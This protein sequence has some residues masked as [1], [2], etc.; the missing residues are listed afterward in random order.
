MCRF[1]TLGFQGIHLEVTCNNLIVNMHQSIY[2]SDGLLGSPRWGFRPLQCN[3]KN[4]W[5]A[6]KKLTSEGLQRVEI[7]DDHM[8]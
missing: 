2:Q 7:L 6:P 8:I 1:H 4:G 3:T 5:R